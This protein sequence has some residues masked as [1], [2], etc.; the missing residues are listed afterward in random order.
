MSLQEY[1][2]RILAGPDP[3]PIVAAGHPVLRGVAAPYTGQLAP[4]TLADLIELMRRTMRAAPGVGLA[5][6]QIGIPL[7]LAVIEDP[8]GLDPELA[9][10]RDRAPLAFRVL[11]NPRYEPAAP[12]RASFYEGCLSL[13]GWQAVVARHRSVRLTGQDGSGEPLDEIVTGWPARIVQHETDHLGGTLYIDRA[14]LRSLAADEGIGASFGAEP[15]PLTAA[16]VLGF[17]LA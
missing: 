1:V 14:E 8:G 13:P 10:V 6:P 5:A 15:T 4:A 17:D 12:E 7:A 9:A 3:A 11:V 16:R 2:E